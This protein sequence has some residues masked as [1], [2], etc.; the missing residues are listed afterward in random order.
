MFS[1]FAHNLFSELDT[2]VSAKTFSL[3]SVQFIWVQMLQTPLHVVAGY[4]N[5]EIL[6]ILLG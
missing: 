2:Q 6:K 3:Y 5:V 1:L 4:N